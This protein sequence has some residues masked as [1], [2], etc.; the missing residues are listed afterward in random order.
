MLKK[1]NTKFCVGVTSFIQVKVLKG[2][3]WYKDVNA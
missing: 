1:M 3:G 2:K